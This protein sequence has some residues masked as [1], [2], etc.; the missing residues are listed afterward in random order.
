MFNRI[1]EPDMIPYDSI[2]AWQ[3]D[4]QMVDI[5]RHYGKIINVFDYR[6]TTEY[7]EEVHILDDFIYSRP[8]PI[9]HENKC[10]HQ[11]GIE[12]RKKMLEIIK[13]WVL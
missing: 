8:T 11:A 12:S 2:F 4:K 3:M 1:F 7:K 10:V 13:E 6:N 5:F 9:E